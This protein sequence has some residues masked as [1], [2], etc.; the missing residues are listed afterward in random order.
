MARKDP[1]GEL[2][3]KAQ[4]FFGLAAKTEGDRARAHREDVPLENAEASPL[5]RR[6]G[7]E[8]ETSHARF[9]GRPSHDGFELVSAG[10]ETSS[11]GGGLPPD[12]GT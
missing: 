4:M 5:K 8:V 2:E 11:H 9:A 6:R 7:A 10:T 1:G 3:A 12:D